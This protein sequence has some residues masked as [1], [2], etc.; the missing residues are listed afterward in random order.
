MPEGHWQIKA[1]LEM[2]LEGKDNESSDYTKRCHENSI[3]KYLNFGVES[4]VFS[5]RYSNSKE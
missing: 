2:H 1:R 4:N 5:A 3:G